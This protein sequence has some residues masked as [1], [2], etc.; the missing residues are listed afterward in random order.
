M[1]RVVELYPDLAGLDGWSWSWSRWRRD[2]A[3]HRVQARSGRATD[4]LYIDSVEQA[5]I[6]HTDRSGVPRLHETGS[7]QASWTR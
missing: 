2:L 7:R 3:A 4:L 1:E 5:A 6:I